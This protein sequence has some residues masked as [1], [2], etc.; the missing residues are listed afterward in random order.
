[1]KRSITLLLVFLAINVYNCATYKLETN[2]SKWLE[3]ELPP[4]SIVKNGEVFFE[5]KLSGG[6]KFSVYSDEIIDNDASYY[7]TL[8]MQDFGWSLKGDNTWT[9]PQGTRDKKYGHIYVNTSRMVAIY[10]YPE[11]T[12]SAFKVKI[13][14]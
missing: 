13:K 7:Y 10:F 14:E 4:S 5:G 1:M 6:S 8:L 12:Y 9:S 11:R 2:T 3:Y